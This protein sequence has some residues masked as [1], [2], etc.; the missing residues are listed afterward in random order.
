LHDRGIPE[1]ESRAQIFSVA[2][3]FLLL[4]LQTPDEKDGVRWRIKVVKKQ[5]PDFPID[6]G[7][8]IRER[9]VDD[10]QS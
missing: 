4:S 7:I 9:R 6:P 1:I 3:L 2:R 5:N 10:G 8:L